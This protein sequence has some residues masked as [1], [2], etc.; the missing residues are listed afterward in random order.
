VAQPASMSKRSRVALSPAARNR[1]GPG[2]AAP[3][4]A[5]RFARD[6]LTRHGADEEALERADL[7]VSELVTNAV[8]HAGTP[9][10][11]SVAVVDGTAHVEVQDG[12]AGEVTPRN[13]GDGPGRPG[14]YGLWLVESLSDSWG[15][16]RSHPIGKK[17][18]LRLSL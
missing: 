15:V 6:V 2:P 17:I 5:R 11:L 13:P 4:R 16:E 3:S 8:V 1:F 10:S 18:W 14:G 9:V 7:L 12:G